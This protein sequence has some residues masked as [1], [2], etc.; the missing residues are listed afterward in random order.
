MR[1]VHLTSRRE[2]RVPAVVAAVGLELLQVLRL[3]NHVVPVDFGHCRLAHIPALCIHT[4]YTT[5]GHV[6]TMNTT[7]P[8]APHMYTLQ[9]TRQ[10]VRNKTSLSGGNP[11]Q[12]MVG[13]LHILTLV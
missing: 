8:T 2:K 7:G 6:N 1:D 9:G 10:C 12:P 3:R 13:F 11:R 4:M 5:Q